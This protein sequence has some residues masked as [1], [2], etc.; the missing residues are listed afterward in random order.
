[1]AGK[2]L[3]TPILGS[4]SVDRDLTT[5]ALVRLITAASVF[6]LAFGLC[7]DRSRANLVLRAIAAIRCGYAASGLI[8]F[9]VTLGW[10]L[11][12]ENKGGMRGMV[13]ATFINRNSVATYAGIGLI[14]ICGLILQLYRR[15]VINIGGAW[16]FRISNFIEVTGGKGAILIGGA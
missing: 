1:M 5:L 13:T 2:A 16:R 7:R 9:A 15:E 4:I 8:A 11:W 6:W 3:N 12:V 10:V 14:A